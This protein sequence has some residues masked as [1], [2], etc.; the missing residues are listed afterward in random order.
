MNTTWYIIEKI[1]SSL[2]WEYYYIENTLL[3]GIFPNNYNSKAL[4]AIFN[5]VDANQIKLITTS[6]STKEWDILKTTY[7]WI[8]DVKGLNF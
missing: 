4:H 1:L 2:V 7:E 8:S 3:Y 5:R 6:E